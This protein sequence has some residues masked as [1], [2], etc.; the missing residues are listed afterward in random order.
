MHKVIMG[1][2]NAVTCSM[3]GGKFFP[4]SLKFHYKACARKN[5]FTLGSCSHC[6]V[7]LPSQEIRLHEKRCSSNPGRVVTSEPIDTAD[8]DEETGMTLDGRRPCPIC[9]RK[10][11]HSR[12]DTH[13]AICEAVEKKRREKANMSG[14]PPSAS[15]PIPRLN[16]ASEAPQLSS[17][18]DVPRRD[19]RGVPLEVLDRDVAAPTSSTRRM[20][21]ERPM[22]QPLSNTPREPVKAATMS[23]TSAKPQRDAQPRATADPPSPA[24][25]KHSSR[26]SELREMQAAIATLQRRIDVLEQM[27]P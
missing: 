25:Q 27:S 19:A 16:P 13:I 14:R 12:A 4:A 21:G 24:Q 22:T 6:S 5:G 7:T 26:A 17:R 10:F 8:V 11:R 9:G 2:E 18:R 3:C 23:R 15:T 1:V 20:A